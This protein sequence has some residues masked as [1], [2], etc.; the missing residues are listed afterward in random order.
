MF[1]F[2]LLRKV[3]IA[4]NTEEVDSV[5]YEICSEMIDI[6]L[7]ISFWHTPELVDQN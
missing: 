3:Y 7:D 5:R 6:F 1:L 4:T 2:E